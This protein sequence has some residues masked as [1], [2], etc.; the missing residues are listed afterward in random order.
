MSYD[1]IPKQMRT[2]RH[3]CEKVKP[4]RFISVGVALLFW[5]ALVCQWPASAAETIRTPGTFVHEFS[6]FSFPTN[7]GI[8]VRVSLDKYDKEGRDVSAGY[9]LSSRQ[10][11]VTVFVYPAPKNFAPLPQERIESVSEA[12]VKRHFEQV[13]QDVQRKHSNAQISSEVAFDLKQEKMTRKGQ[14]AVFSFE[15]RFAGLRQP[16]QSELYLFMLEPD[17]MFL[18]DERFFVKF[19]VTY[20]AAEKESAEK[21]F[22]NF[23]KSLS[24]PT[25]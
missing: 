7:V 19:R 25:K 16:V 10:M 14:R 13:K 2:I 11:A 18:I 23:L 12:I 6:H 9:N 17:T 5:E 3:C 15:D 22:Q 24:W 20:P 1:K 8:A 21:E 4:L